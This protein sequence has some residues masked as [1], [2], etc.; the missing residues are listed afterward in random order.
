MLSIR[1]GLALRV[2]TFS[3][4]SL[5]TSMEQRNKAETAEAL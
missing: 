4:V 1:K 2:V 3:S 5:G